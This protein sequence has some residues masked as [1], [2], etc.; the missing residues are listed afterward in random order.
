VHVEFAEEHHTRVTK[1]PNDRRVLLGHTLGKQR[2]R[3]RRA[4]AGRINVVLEGS[5]FVAVV[6][7]DAVVGVADGDVGV[8]VPQAATRI[9]NGTRSTDADFEEDGIAGD[10]RS[11]SR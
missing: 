9:R 6:S 4:N 8:S 2:A 1:L 5:A 10:S 7:A 3:R 11:S